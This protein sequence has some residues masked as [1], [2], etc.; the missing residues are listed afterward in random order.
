MNFSQ[1]G[2]PN[3]HFV[4]YLQNGLIVACYQGYVDIVMAL[5]Q[6]PHLDVNWQDNEGNT[7]LITAAQAGKALC[8]TSYMQG[9]GRSVCFGYFFLRIS[10]Q[11][12]ERIYAA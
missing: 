12:P 7:A 11:I 4:F 8:I 9:L 6:C 3:F 1:A 10:F 5:A 2:N